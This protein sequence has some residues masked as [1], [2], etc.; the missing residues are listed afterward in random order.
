M[1]REIRIA[2]TYSVA[3]ALLRQ[4]L[5]L[6]RRA[7]MKSIKIYI[8][9]LIEGYVIVRGI[10][11]PGSKRALVCYTISPFL[12]RQ[13]SHTNYR[14]SVAIVNQLALCGYTV[15]IVHFTYVGAIDYSQYDLIFGFGEPFENSFLEERKLARI[16]YLTGAYSQFQ[17]RAEIDRVIATNK[18]FGGSLQPKRLVKWTWSKSLMMSDAVIVVGNEWTLSTY[19]LQTTSP[20]FPINATAL[21]G[22]GAKL[23]RERLGNSGKFLWFGSAG[24]VHKGLDLC[25][26]FF[27]ENPC[28]ELHICG[29]TERDFMTLF[30][31]ELNQPNIH[32]HGFI[33]VGS[34]Q[35]NTIV[36][37]CRFALLPTCSEGQATALLTVMAD[38]LIPIATRNSGVN[39]GE[40]GIL[41]E[42]LTS[43]LVAEAISRALALS[44][45]EIESMSKRVRSYIKHQH[46]L[47]SFEVSLSQIFASIGLRA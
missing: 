34:S 35:Y 6:F 37:D 20:M 16:H 4:A 9:N 40:L 42:G 10:N 24:L 28:Y 31:V 30:Q 32:F 15:D 29:P 2:L 14:E 33:K 8:R 3:L 38:G 18:K 22:S 5:E 44:S 41:I 23:E 36:N 11:A 43:A 27:R 46:S 45:G 21:E 39:V 1:P 7:S 26:E 47:E 17:N 19:T 13:V 12:L 25:L